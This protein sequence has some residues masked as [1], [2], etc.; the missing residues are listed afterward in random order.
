[1]EKE[2]TIMKEWKKPEV[3]DFETKEVTQGGGFQYYSEG[4][5]YHT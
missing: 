4:S 2:H 3:V 1:M 5:Y